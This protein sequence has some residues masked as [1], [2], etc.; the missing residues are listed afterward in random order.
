MQ[1]LTN[2]ESQR[3]MAVMGDLLDRL[4]YL[5]Y[6][7]LEP[8]TPL[9]DDLRESRCLNSAELLREHWRWEQLYLQAAQ[10]M[11]SRQDDIADQV[12]V[13]AR[14]L[15]RDLRENPVAVEVVYHKG[16][17]AHDRSEDL[18]MLVKALSELT[19]LTHA[20]L[21]KTLEDA[22][23]KKELMAV[24]ENRMKQA[25]DERLTIREKLTEMRKTKE[26]EVALLDAQVQKLRTELHTI[27]QTASHEL[28]M[29]ET[30]LKEAQA[31]A[32]DQHSEE[33][34]VLLD[35]ASAL[36]LR[37]AK[38]AQEHQEEEDGLRKK[39]CKMAAEVAAVVEKFDSEM[40]AM[41]TELRALEENFKNER[42]QCDQ[43][44][45]HFLKID[46]EQSRIDA[47]ERVLE[48]IRAREREKQM[49]IYNAATR[50]Q[51]VYRGLLC[52]R[53]YAK[54]VAKNK[55]GGGG[56]KGKG[57]KGKKK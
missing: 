13:T 33:M 2:V 32:H 11:D 39:K 45:E 3:M 55:K 57:K 41:E 46:E 22:K 4:N 54:M 23:S 52:R 30:D 36:E 8:Q 38:M 42:E 43:F 27:N 19:D 14:A 5:T 15:C 51:K 34:K 18:Q 53:E 17:T 49:M 31:K 20:Q 40:E 25:E 24:A 28:M 12:R 47:E 50:I 37:A 44:N 21:D 35:Q 29:I 1:K 7:P 10:A 6:V 9:L 26:E 16:T 48:E 56:K